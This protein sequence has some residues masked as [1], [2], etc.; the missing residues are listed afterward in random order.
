[1]NPDERFDIKVRVLYRL[2]PDHQRVPFLENQS[3][4]SRVRVVPCASKEQYHS[5]QKR[6]MKITMVA[7]VVLN[8][9]VTVL[10]LGQNTHVRACICIISCLHCS[11]SFSRLLHADALF[12]LVER[13][14]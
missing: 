5:T 6:Y 4:K 2:S 10:N 8:H 7:V 3:D 14:S 12:V 1:M 11:C 9:P 13:M